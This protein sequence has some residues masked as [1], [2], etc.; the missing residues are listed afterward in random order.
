[1]T[2]PYKTGA[3][4]VWFLTFRLIP[5]CYVSFC[6]YLEYRK[7]MSLALVM[8]LT[9]MKNVLH[10]FTS[11]SC[12]NSSVTLWAY[13]RGNVESSVTH[14]KEQDGGIPQCIDRYVVK[15]RL[16]R[17]RTDVFCSF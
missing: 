2:W 10:N 9:G 8:L 1:M 7:E 6:L 11:D 14:G 12:Y 3:V 5:F 17:R 16:F 15:N 4:I 13:V